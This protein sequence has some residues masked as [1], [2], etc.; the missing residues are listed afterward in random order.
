MALPKIFLDKRG[1]VNGRDSHINLSNFI[2]LNA[3]IVA[4][5][6]AQLSTLYSFENGLTLSGNT[7]NL[8]GVLNQDTTI[9]GNVNAYAF[10]FDNLSEFNVIAEG[11]VLQGSSSIN[12]QTPDVIA[13]TATAG[14]VLTLVDGA[15]G[16]CEWQ[17]I[18]PVTVEVNN[19]L[20][21]DGGVVQLG[22][23]LV[24]DTEILGA[25][26][27]FALTGI[28]NLGLDST[29]L[30][31]TSEEVDIEAYSI[32]SIH[33]GGTL[34]LE[35]S[36]D[37]I[38][39]TPDYGTSEVDYILR[40]NTASTGSAEWKANNVFPITTT[41]V[42]ISLN[43]TH[44]TVLVTTGGGNINISLPDAALNDGLTYIVK[45]IGTGTTTI[46]SAAQDIYST[47]QV[48]SVGTTTSG[49]TLTLQAHAATNLWYLLK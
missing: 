33:T 12:L 1:T 7:V 6:T 3:H 18:P 27:N 14:Q 37:V 24:E 5:I 20:N 11:V 9:D 34:T 2:N 30:V 36:T 44:H 41:A 16:E 32:M 45:Q 23:S 31:S 13:L 25:G 22:G 47:A 49:E 4:V 15:T 26:F 10:N 21:I 8:G 43:T 29:F 35:G 46:A 28:V 19:G 38:L 42:N 40:T 39:R 17:D 48:A